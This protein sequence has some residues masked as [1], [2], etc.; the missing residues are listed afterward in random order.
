M[1]GGMIAP[2]LSTPFGKLQEERDEDEDPYVE[3]LLDEVDDAA[4]T[5][6]DAAEEE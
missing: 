5:Y 6:E 1:P 3:E 4:S 2:E